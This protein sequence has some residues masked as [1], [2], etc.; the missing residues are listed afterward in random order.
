MTVAAAA[1]AGCAIAPGELG[2]PLGPIAPRGPAIAAP[3][4]RPGL[5]D[6][7]LAA[8]R[9]ARHRYDAIEHTTTVDADPF[10]QCEIRCCSGWQD[11]E[12]GRPTWR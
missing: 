12:L 6:L 3:A 2:A 1:L 8:A 10:H 7:E 4:A 5:S 9:H 11:L